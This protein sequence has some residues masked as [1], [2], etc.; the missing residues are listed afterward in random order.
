LKSADILLWG[1]DQRG[2][3]GRREETGNFLKIHIRQLRRLSGEKKLKNQKRNIQNCARSHVAGTF[4]RPEKKVESERG[5]K[6]K[7][8]DV[9]RNPLQEACRRGSNT[10]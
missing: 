6:K 9:G 3:L 8:E 1:M 10:R 7:F 2:E 5:R 4:E